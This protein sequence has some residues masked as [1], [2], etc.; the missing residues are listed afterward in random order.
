MADMVIGD[1]P[2][3]GKD[4]LSERFGPEEQPPFHDLEKLEEYWGA[5]WGVN[6]EIGKLRV[7]YMHRPGDELKTMKKEHYVPEVDALIG[8][9]ESYYWKGAEAPDLVK[10]QAQHD[11]FTDT[12]RGHGVKVVYSIDNPVTLRKTVNTRDVAAA[13]PGGMLIMRTAPHMRRGEERVATRTLGSLGVPIIRTITGTGT[14]EGGGFMMLDPKHAAVAQSW[15]C[16]D[17][18]I[19]QVKEILD[20]MGIELIVVPVTGYGVHIDG[21][22]SV[23]GDHKA[24]VNTNMMPY[25][26]I[27]KLK[28][29]K[30]DLIEVAPNEGWAINSIVIEPGLLCMIDGFPRTVEKL[31][32]EGIQVIPIPWDENIKSGGGPHCGT[33]PLMR[34]Y[35]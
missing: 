22:I 16:N 34:D 29:M 5:P 2:Y 32:K 9:G 6:S 30:Y 10:A 18:A 19:R 35:I 11:Y 20:P 3:E 7:V 21:M 25:S 13:I 27:R 23:V 1:T 26:F 8:P 15:R 17:E 24:L 4:S 28:D 14:L 12:L 31:G 33:C